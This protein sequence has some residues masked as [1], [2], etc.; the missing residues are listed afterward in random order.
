MMNF[1]PL[2]W[3]Y[4]LSMT[5][6]S[7]IW[8]A[9]Y[10]FRR[11][12]YKYGSQQQRRYMVPIIS[13]GN[14]TFGGTGKTPF[15]VWVSNYLNQQNKKILV[16]TRG[17][18]GKLENS[19]GII[20]SGR[21]MG[22]NPVEFGDEALLLSRRLK[23]AS[24]VVGKNRSANLDYY[25]DSEKP[26][27]V[28]LDDGYQHLRLKRDLN[29][30]LFDA[31][32]PMNRYRVAPLGYMR[33]GFKSLKDAQIAVIGRVDLV[34]QSKIEELENIIKKYGPRDLPIVH[35]SYGPT[36]VSDFQ[37][38]PKFEPAELQGRRV[39]AVSGIA[40]PDSFYQL[41]ET[42]GAEIV[43]KVTYPDH[44]HY[45]QMDIDQI[46]GKAQELNAIVVTTE[47]DM[48]KL[49]RLTNDDRFHYIEIDINI[50]KGELALKQKIEKLLGVFQ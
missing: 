32:M 9:V 40:S 26:D 10:R 34:S 14:L 28:V 8:E 22:V 7:W 11:F 43:S 31:T 44:Y 46:L 19:H 30:V 6:L 29:I 37:Y 17:Y 27:V 20:R 49:R 36:S 47:K 13:I 48:V 45:R 3:F 42:N 41:L 39:V 21:K 2:Y 16:L 25:F 38:R 35:F 23:N 5:P 4:Q 50:L 1:K 12:N 24:I 33:E 18:R 15:T